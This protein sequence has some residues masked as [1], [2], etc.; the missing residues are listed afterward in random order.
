ML[1]YYYHYYFCCH[2]KKQK[3]YNFVMEKKQ[4]IT[5]KK[6][7]AQGAIARGAIVLLQTSTVFGT[8]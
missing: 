3:L 8:R 5:M 6:G 1:Y 7:I 2:N 4:K